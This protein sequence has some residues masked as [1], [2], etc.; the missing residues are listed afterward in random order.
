MAQLAPQLP[1]R[2]LRR[3][4]RLLRPR[5]AQPRT[6]PRPRGAIASDL[7]LRA[8]GLGSNVLHA[9]SAVPLADELHRVSNPAID[10][11]GNLFAMISGPRGERTPVSIVRIGR[12]LQGTPLRPRPAQR[13]RARLRPR[14][15]SLRQARAPKAPSTASRPK[16]TTSPPSP[17]ALG[18][19]TGIA[20]DRDGNLFVGDRS[21]TIFKV[22]SLTAHATP[23]R[24]SS[25]PHSEPSVAAYHLAFRDD[26][27]L[28]VAA[29]PRDRFEPAHLRHR[30]QLATPASSTRAS[31]P[32]A[33][34]SRSTPTAT[35]T[36]P[37]RFAAAA[38]SS[39][40]RPT[41]PPR[42]SSSPATTSSASASSTTA[43][44][45]SPPTAPSSTSTS[46]FRAGRWYESRGCGETFRSQME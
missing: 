10:A 31:R 2:L 40:S 1:V 33:G 26:G 20:F 18:V 30:T 19:A 6:P 8:N 4:H 42:S 38:A 32:P 9:N 3:H 34:F 43:A 21:G 39:A 17:K 7:M 14:Q 29:P 35:S 12:D 13:L 15:L 36:S 37:P 44:P 28:L 46:A 27:I 25:S 24:S 11:E 41:P 45:P 16:A 22:G 5:A 23:A